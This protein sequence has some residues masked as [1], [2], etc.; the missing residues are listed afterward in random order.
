[1][2][3]YRYVYM[4]QAFFMKNKR[5]RIF[6]FVLHEECIKD[7]YFFKYVVLDGWV[8]CFFQKEQRSCYLFT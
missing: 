7:Y 3:I 8:L 1:M 5:K 2:Q 6:A 4:I